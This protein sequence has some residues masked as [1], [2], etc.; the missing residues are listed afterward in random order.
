LTA[1]AFSSISVWVSGDALLGAISRFFGVDTSSALFRGFVY[2]IIG[3][4]VSSYGC[5]DD[6]F[7]PLPS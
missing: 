4:L 2:A 7:C 6:T 1:I 5:N 3:S